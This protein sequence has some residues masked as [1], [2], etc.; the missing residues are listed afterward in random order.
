MPDFSGP[1]L[2][3]KIKE[4]FPWI[5]II[6]I[7]GYPDIIGSNNAPILQKPIDER[8]LLKLVGK[9]LGNEY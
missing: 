1:E 9:E 3:K 4:N 6:F 8:K 7:S 5:K 2:A